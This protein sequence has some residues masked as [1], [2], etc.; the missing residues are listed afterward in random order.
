MFRIAMMRS[1]AVG[2]LDFAVDFALS[3]R[4]A[5]CRG[6]LALVDFDR[7]ICR[8]RVIAFPTAEKWNDQSDEL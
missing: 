8:F 3:V 1:L 4:R 5:V 7:M 2:S 6:L